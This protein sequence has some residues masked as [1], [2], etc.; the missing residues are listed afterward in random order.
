MDVGH[1]LIAPGA[2]SARGVDE[3]VFNQALAQALV[4][5]LTQRG[6]V[7]RPINFDGQIASL[8]ARPQAA[9]G[10]RKLTN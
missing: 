9:A 10:S 4:P 2:I 8:D 1:T 7:V 6:I 5:A 3:L